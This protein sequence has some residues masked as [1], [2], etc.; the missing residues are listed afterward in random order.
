MWWRFV[1]ETPLDAAPTPS[2]PDAHSTDSPDHRADTLTSDT[3]DSPDREA[4]AYNAYLA[5]LAAQDKPKQW[6]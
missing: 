4:A 3:A 6:H 5:E 2:Q 1:H